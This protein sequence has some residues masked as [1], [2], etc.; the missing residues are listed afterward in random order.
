MVLTIGFLLYTEVTL[1][2]KILKF[3][4]KIF[5]PLL[6]LKMLSLNILN[7]EVKLVAMLTSRITLLLSVSISKVQSCLYKS[8]DLLKDWFKLLT[9]LDSPSTP[10]NE[11]NRKP[12]FI[13]LC[14]TGL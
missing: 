3:T 2:F 10:T 4:L 7:L 5:N 14:S 9:C 13:I 12:N 1:L 11:K 6:R 8:V